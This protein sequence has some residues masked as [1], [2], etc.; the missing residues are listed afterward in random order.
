MFSFANK[1]KTLQTHI[2][3]IGLHH[4]LDYNRLEK[5]LYDFIKDDYNIDSN[6]V[7]DFLKDTKYSYFEKE[8]EIIDLPFLDMQLFPKSATI[9]D[10][11]DF[12]FIYFIDQQ[13]GIYGFW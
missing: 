13:G 1:K 5:S 9:K 11:N 8:E 12:S 2:S 10:K 7:R 4:K 6:I 3:I